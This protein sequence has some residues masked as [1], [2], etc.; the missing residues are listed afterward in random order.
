VPTHDFDILAI[1]SELENETYLAEALLFPE[2]NRHDETARKTQGN[3]RDS[4]LHLLDS[5]PTVE[6]HSRRLPK[7][8][9]I[10]AI[11][12]SVKPP[13]RNPYW[14][15]PVPLTFHAVCW[16]QPGTHHALVPALTIEVV[17]DSEESLAELLPR[18]IRGEL[19]RRGAAGRL[20]TLLWYQRVVQLQ[21]EKTRVELALA[22]PK[23]SAESSL[24]ADQAPA[25][26]KDVATNLNAIGIPQAVEVDDKVQALA[27]LLVGKHGRSVLLVG[28]SG[29]GKTALVYELVRQRRQHHLSSTRF[30]E[31]T[32]AR[33]MVGADSFGDWQERCQQVI[34]EASTERAIL[35]LGNLFELAEVARHATTPQGMAGFFRPYI[36]RGDL[37][38]IVEC[39]PQQRDLL[40][41]DHP[42]LL[43]SFSVLGL[44]RP[45]PK[46]VTTI[47]R[48][49]VKAD[50]VSDQAIDKV[51]RLHRR[52]ANYSAYPG[53]PLRF[54]K[55]LVTEIKG[56]I[57]PA[58]VAQ[59][60]AQETGLPA[61]MVDDSLPLQLAKTQEFFAQ[62][63]L[64]QEEAVELVVDLLASVKAGLSPPGRPIASLLFIGPTGVGKTEMARNLAQYLFRDRKRMVRFDMSEFA[65]PASVERL[66]GGQGGGQGL[67]T[68]K[69]RE[70]P[71]GVVLFDEL[72]KADPAFFDLLLQI[73]GEGR[74]SDEAGRLA[75]FT[76]SVIV[77][78]S[79][80]GAASF[81]RGPLGFRGAEKGQDRSR[82]EFT[83]AVKAAFR[84]EL[85]NRIDRLVP[86]APL[87][88]EV[89]TA[90]ATRELERL[91]RRDGL[92]HSK[93]RFEVG[94]GVAEFLAQVGYDRRYG[95]R[96]LKRAIENTLLEPLARIASEHAGREVLV[97][98]KLADEA[99]V[100]TMLMLDEVVK[101]SGNTLEGL[102][103]RALA[104]RRRAQKIGDSRQAHTLRN[105]LHRL[106]DFKQ[107]Q[108]RRAYLSEEMAQKLAGLPRRKELTER[109]NKAIKDSRQLETEVVLCQQGYREPDPALDE[110]LALQYNG[111]NDLTL[112]LY[113]SNFD[114]TD[115]ATLIVYFEK[116]VDPRLLLEAYRALWKSQKIDFKPYRLE[117]GTQETEDN[118]ADSTLRL[119][120][121]EE[122][123]DR[124]LWCEPVPFE[125]C[126][127]KDRIGIALE[128]SGP[129]VLPLMLGESGLH[130]FGA[131]HPHHCEVVLW[132]APLKNYPP[133]LD[134]HLRKRFT[135]HKRRFYNQA[136][137][138]VED[139]HLDRRLPWNGK[140]LDKILA[141]FI[142]AELLR[143]AEEAC[144]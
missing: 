53:R 105:A 83:S 129:M 97:K 22:S 136:R 119:P 51:E 58:D 49:V 94:A 72:E 19:Q 125:K 108:M 20:D 43:Q 61:F 109:L 73:L 134:L 48:S 90:V 91:Q 118:K 82:Q 93:L 38:A 55:E 71:F 65:D 50:R 116:G 120:Y 8:M 78:T 12:V 14:N 40:E 103:T 112:Q 30:W 107:R 32:G 121:G 117:L 54:L 39:T 45:E 77:M 92:A 70:Q 28:P 64:G 31:T 98:V 111:L 123:D 80:L 102:A 141:D 131:S 27:E 5:L 89:A 16:Q 135:G 76:N 1:I 60:F 106:E 47:L 132:A 144:T 57:G 126:L 34:A 33:L 68:G 13:K 36:E 37:L 15:E 130:V 74:L 25:I 142:R 3:L 115:Q 42:N 66:V 143:T 24:S 21:M 87:T 46:Q 124:A 85:F 29:V 2:L 122:L 95:A 4:L 69:V 18:N 99:L 11:E 127:G 140:A 75:D 139:P 59:A 128:L 110:K 81:S 101:P 79:N 56:E 7:D 113:G 35:L 133:P 62:R 86:F 17:A 96:P 52:Y 9:E 100:W 23:K 6:I 44:K 26:L 88:R 84:P 10:R 137:G 63:I 67:L 138:I 41:R 114:H 104:G